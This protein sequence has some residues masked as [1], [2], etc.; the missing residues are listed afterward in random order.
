M[1]GALRSAAP[2]DALTRHREADLNT[3]TL[4]GDRLGLPAEAIT[5]THRWAFGLGWLDEG[6][7]C[8][9]HRWEMTRDLEEIA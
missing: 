2:C 3:R 9:N 4:I 8:V 1:T 6:C 5:P 7:C